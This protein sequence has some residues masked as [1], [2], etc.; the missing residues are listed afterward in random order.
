M[1]HLPVAFDE[2]F[3]Y[4]FRIHLRRYDVPGRVIPR[5]RRQIGLSRRSLR[6]NT[7]WHWF[8]DAVP[9]AARAL[10][11]SVYVHIP[12]CESLCYYCACNKVITKH[13]ERPTPTCAT[14]R[15]R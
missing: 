15:V 12:F 11:L 4:C 14:L 13:H 2:R 7:K 9:P 5:T 6:R 10:P 3:R 8:N 1:R